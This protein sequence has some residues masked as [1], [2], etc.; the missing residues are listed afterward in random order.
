MK[1]AYTYDEYT[2]VYVIKISEL[3]WEEFQQI[4]REQ[5]SGKV[6]VEFFETPDRKLQKRHLTDRA[7]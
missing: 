1:I 2:H 4:F 5:L 7:Q 6:R 3:V